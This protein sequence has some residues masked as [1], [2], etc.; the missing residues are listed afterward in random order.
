MVITSKNIKKPKPFFNP[1]PEAYALE[2]KRSDQWLYSH[3]VERADGTWSKPPC[4]AAGYPCDGT[5]PNNLTSFETAFPTCEANLGKLSGLAYSIQASS[6]IKAIDIDHVFDPDTEEW[7]QEALQELRIINT[8]VE[9]SPSHTGVHVF[10]TCPIMLE[11]GNKTQ[12]DGTK[13]EIY[14]DKHIVTVK[15]EVVEGFPT[16]INEVDPELIMQL[17]NKW[18]SYKAEK[19]VKREASVKSDITSFDIPESFVDDPD[20]P[21]KGLSPTK[22]QV[23]EYCRNAPNGFGDKFDNLFNGDISKYKSKSEADMG[24]AGMIAF[25]TSDYFIIKEIIHKSALWDKK[26]ERD[27]Y[28]QRTITVSYTHLTL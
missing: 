14:F 15:A 10:F 2:M 8:R 11:N 18:F 27:D 5:D 19:P 28:C 9:W 16:T 17:C 4:N 26:W 3:L 12:P 6:P 13:R 22:Y 1:D 24:I 20:N 25:H 7:N 21:F 23:M